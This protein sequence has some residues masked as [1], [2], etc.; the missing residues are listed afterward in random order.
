MEDG[1]NEDRDYNDVVLFVHFEPFQKS[2][3]RNSFC[4]FDDHTKPIYNFLYA[5]KKVYYTNND[6]TVSEAVATLR[7]PNN[8]EI[9]PN[10][11]DYCGNKMRTGKVWVE[12]IVIVGNHSTPEELWN[13]N[14]NPSVGA[15]VKKAH[16][17]SSASFIYY[18]EKW[19]YVDMDDFV[20]SPSGFTYLPGI[21]FMM[22]F[23]LAENWNP[24]YKIPS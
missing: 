11:M 13:L 5:Y 12:K 20:Y 22:N 7:I 24:R 4:H 18:A 19:A 14:P 8:T 17:N 21:H 1:D 3:R 6:G 10:P 9:R 15:Y 2:I 16:S 23:T